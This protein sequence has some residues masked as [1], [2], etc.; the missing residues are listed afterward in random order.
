MATVH[1]ILKASGYTDE[2]ITGMDQKTITVFNNVLSEATAQREAAELAK[3]SYVDYYE[4]QISPALL[5]WD[6]EKSQQDNAMAQ[7]RAENAYYRTQNEAARQSGFIASDAPGYTPRDAGGRYIPNVAGAT[8]GSPTF[9]VETVY[10]RAGDAIGVLAD[11]QWEHERL[12]GTK[13]PL[14]PSELVRQADSVKLH[15]REYASRHFK[16][17]E[18]RAEMQKQEQEKHDS[19]IRRD[20]EQARDRVWAERTGSNPDVRLG[21]S[22]RFSDASKAVRAG[23]RV[24]PL[25]LSDQDRRRAT[26]QA[27]RDD[28]AEAEK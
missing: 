2:Q 18:R 23:N 16:W 10:Q 28:L 20:A 19:Q 13:M 27:I 11:I 14:S 5:A 3:R 8:P 4:Q 21:Q 24:D 17:E 9:S 12:Y 15:P 1:E 26:A 25:S 6:S 7:L 22:S